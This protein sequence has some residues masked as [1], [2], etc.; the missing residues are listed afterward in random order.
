MEAGSNG[1]RVLYFA[2]SLSCGTITKGGEVS[3]S[4][5]ATDVISDIIN[6]RHRHAD[7]EQRRNNIFSFFP[8][9][10]SFFSTFSILNFPFYS[11]EKGS[12]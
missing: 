4:H 5:T 11:F 7:S 10:F 9:P 8:F 12:L 6:A 1:V 3:R 2:A